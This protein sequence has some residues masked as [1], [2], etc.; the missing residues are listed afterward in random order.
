M[1]N[2]HANGQAEDVGILVRV[3]AETLYNSKKEQIWRMVQN[4]F[5]KGVCN[6]YRCQ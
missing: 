3:S 4:G 6:R 2:G 5:A 1:G